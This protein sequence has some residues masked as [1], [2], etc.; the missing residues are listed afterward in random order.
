MATRMALKMKNLLKTLT[1]SNLLIG[2]PRFLFFILIRYL[3]LRFATKLH[4]VIFTH[5]ST[6]SA[7]STVQTLMSV[8]LPPASP[9]ETLDLFSRAATELWTILSSVTAVH[10]LPMSYLYGRVSNSLTRMAW[11]LNVVDSVGHII[12]LRLSRLIH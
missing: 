4:H 7:N 9:Q 8:T 10:Q 11:V 6:S 1:K 2:P 3:L 12:G 5:T